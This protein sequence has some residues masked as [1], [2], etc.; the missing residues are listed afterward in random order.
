MCDITPDQL[1]HIALALTFRER[2]R[3][4]DLWKSRGS[5][6]GKLRA[7]KFAAVWS[8]RLAASPADCL[9]AQEVLHAFASSTQPPVAPAVP[10]VTPP[11]LLTQAK[12]VTTATAHWIA[13]GS[14]VPTPEQLAE[15]LA[16]C[17]DC[18][19]WDAS[20]FAGTGRCNKCGCSTQAKLRMAT[21]ACPEGKWKDIITVQK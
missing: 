1:E 20:A 17:H 8:K 19:L 4:R 3:W 15:R 9:L 21:E 13:A 14:P 16:I 12:T 6:R 2:P 11:P 7:Q 10:G 5:R 18:P